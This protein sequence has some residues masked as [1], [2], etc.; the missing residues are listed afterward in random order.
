MT[1]L[2]HT[3]THAFWRHAHTAHAPLVQV[4]R[5][6][7]F[8]REPLCVR[9]VRPTTCWGIHSKLN[10]LYNACVLINRRSNQPYPTPLSTPLSHLHNAHSVQYHSSNG[11][12]S[13][14]RPAHS[15]SISRSSSRTH[16]ASLS[17]SS[18]PSASLKAQSESRGVFSRD[19]HSRRPHAVGALLV[20]GWHRLLLCRVAHGRCDRLLQLLVGVCLGHHKGNKRASQIFGRNGKPCA[21]ALQAS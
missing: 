5:P 6:H 10:T 12:S 2:I 9:D 14:S 3:E 13:L 21:A 8:G 20:V 1:T 15:C 17:L 19:L 4:T 18:P 7:P 16:A 11:R